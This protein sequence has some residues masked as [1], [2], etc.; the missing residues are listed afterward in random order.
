MS[1]RQAPSRPHPSSRPPWL[2]PLLAVVAVLVIG[3][4][5]FGLVSLLRGSG[6]EPATATDGATPNPCATE[7]VPTS[8]VLP[9]PGKVKVNVYN[10]TG[11]SGLASKTASALEKAGFKVG[12]V[13]NDPVGRTIT[14]VGQIR[15]G[16]KAQQRAELLAIYVPGAELVELTRNG[17]N[18]DL[19]M[20]DSFEGLAPEQQVNDALASPRPT[21]TGV[22]CAPDSGATPEE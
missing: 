8:D 5:I 19:A 21:V 1:V 14:G 12:K 11:T 9:P 10:A 2:L 16:P 13:A 22:G 17:P 18:V 15:F 4:L 20:G 6:D 7:M 3:G